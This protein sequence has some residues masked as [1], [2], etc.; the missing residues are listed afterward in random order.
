[1]FASLRRRL[2]ARRADVDRRGLPRRRAGWSGL[3][4]RRPRSRSGCGVMF[5]R[6]RS[7]DHGR[8]CANEVPRQGREWGGEAGR[9]A[10]RPARPGARVPAPAPGR[11]AV[12]RR[13]GD[14]GEAPRPRDHDESAR[15]RS[16][17][18]RRSSR[19]SAVRRAGTCTRSR[20]TA[21]LGPEDGPAPWFDRLAACA[22]P[23]A[24]GRRRS[25]TRSS[26]ALVDRVTRRLRGRRRVGRTVVLRLRFDDFS[27]AT[28]SYT[29]AVPDGRDAGD[30][31]RGAGSSRRRRRRR[32]SSAGSR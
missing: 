17:T 11:A 5:S 14:G 23:R 15:S 20:T 13:A 28:R 29:L 27:R 21:I 18:R 22:R 25:S 1:M 19:C 10:R 31:R 26:S 16:S 2:A 3:R 8:R 7:A 32:S 6:G 9:A 4:A 12:G 30:P 24:A